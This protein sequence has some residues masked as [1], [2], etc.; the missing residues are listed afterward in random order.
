MSHDPGN[1]KY[2]DKKVLYV[3]LLY[4]AALVIWFFIVY[5]LK[6]YKTDMIGFLILCIPLVLFVIVFAFTPY[7]CANVEAQL[8]RSNL[9]SVGLI[10]VL[11]LLSALEKSYTGRAKLGPVM[12]TAIILTLLSLLDIWLPIN[13]L[14]LQK[15]FKSIC[16]VL[17]ITLLIFV[18]YRFYKNHQKNGKEGEKLFTPQDAFMPKTPRK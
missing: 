12:I 9:L 13:Y 18:L 15:H 1:R 5:S 2:H 17:A 8:L 6:L 11:G 14:S 10:L 3:R 4:L 7:L 16:Q